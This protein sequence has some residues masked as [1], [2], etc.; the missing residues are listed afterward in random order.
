MSVEPESLARPQGPP[1][2]PLS[3]PNGTD[4]ATSPG[5]DRNSPSRR[6]TPTVVV[7]AP[8]PPP[9]EP[10]DDGGGGGGGGDGGEGG[11][12][13]EG[14]WWRSVPKVAAITAAVVAAVALAVMFTRPGGVSGAK[15]GEL[16]LQPAGSAG[17]NPFTRSTAET[18]AAPSATPPLPTPSAGAG[19]VRQVYSGGMPGLY[20]GTRSVASCDVGKQIDVLSADASKNKAFA[21][22]LGIAP[23]G[24]PAYLRDLTPVQLRADTRVT[25]HGYRDGRPTAF[26][27]V[28]QAGTAVLVDDRGMPRVRCACGNPLTRPVEQKGGART[29]GQAWS[30]YQPSR[31]VVVAPAPEPVKRFTVRDPDSGEWFTRD[32]GDGKA[33][34]DRKTTPPEN[35]PSGSTPGSPPGGSPA[36]PEQGGPSAPPEGTAPGGTAP[37]SPSPETTGPGP[38]S[39]APGTPGPPGGVSPPPG[40]T[41][42]EQPSGPAASP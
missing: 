2:G 40:G 36:A 18:T 25:N 10:P 4:E 14:P 28:L 38:Q 27:S 13:Q 12:G 29:V 15:E 31:T 1:A 32:S 21:S 30:G 34:G 37:H 3:G 23:S 19:T 24:V 42:P 39:P 35:A 41:V 16:F 22:V 8:P 6:R 17:P 33:A 20:G 9:V 11:G 5:P 7:G 26:Q